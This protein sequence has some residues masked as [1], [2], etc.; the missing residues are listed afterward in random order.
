M[1]DIEIL[2]EDDDILAIFKPSGISVHPDSK[3]NVDKEKTIS[4]WVLKKYPKT[5]DVGEPTILTNGESIQ[6]PGIV[7]RLDKDTSGVL[8]IAKTKEGYYHL[9]KQFKNREIK[10]TYHAFLYGKFRDERG[11]ID[12]PIGRSVGGVRKW[13][14]GNKARGELRDAVTRFK[15][16]KNQTPASFAEVWPLTG[17]THQIR[18]HM[19]AVGHPVVAD[20]L[21]ANTRES[22]LGFKRLALHASRVVFNDLEGRNIEVKAPFP[23]DFQKAMGE[24]GVTSL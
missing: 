6:R 21:Y 5:K 24:L 12:R 16:I 4:D 19:Q 23:E 15:I 14:T 9:K 8:L 22:L 2:F 1:K 3:V 10:K 13:A 11:M 20:P 7:H 17:R 18:V